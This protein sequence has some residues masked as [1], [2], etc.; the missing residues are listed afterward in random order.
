MSKKITRMN[1]REITI[2]YYHVNNIQD[3]KPFINDAVDINGQKWTTFI[4]SYEDLTN[5]TVREPQVHLIADALN[6]PSIRDMKVIR[7]LRR[8]LLAH[9]GRDLFEGDEE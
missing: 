6:D 5:I 2:P 3:G 4:D 9:L 1:G 7:D 8:A